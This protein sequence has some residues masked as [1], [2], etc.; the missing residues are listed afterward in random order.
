MRWL[1]PERGWIPPD[2]FITLAEQSDLI[3]ELG[4]FALREAIHAAAS[5]A[6]DA[7][8]ARPFVSVNL[9]AH[10]FFDPNL[11]PLIEAELEASGLSADRLILEI[12]ETVALLDT[13]ETL[14]AM[15]H[16]NR[17]GVGI[18]LDDFGTGYSSLSYLAMLHPRII[19][20]DQSF[21]R[22]LQQSEQ[23]DLLLETIVSLG[24]KLDMTMLA[25]GIET[26]EQLDRLRRTGCELGQGFA[27]SHAVPSTELHSMLSRGVEAPEA[28]EARVT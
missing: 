24:E 9:S 22:P 4:A 2:S 1:H 21:V 19:K 28:P 14:S 20:I 3:I 17:L 18:A 6:P 23:S 11:I 16:L 5:W 27:F 10:Q 13:A 8:G 15:E 25:E 12:T 7:D 26:R